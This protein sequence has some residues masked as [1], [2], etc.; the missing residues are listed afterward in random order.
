MKD[1]LSVMGPIG[2]QETW[3]IAPLL[4]LDLME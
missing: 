4:A 2:E 3:H 1:L